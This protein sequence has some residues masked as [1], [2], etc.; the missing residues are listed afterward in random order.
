MSDR[1]R[2]VERLSRDETQS[3]HTQMTSL[4]QLLVALIGFA[5]SSIIAA[6]PPPTF[7]FKPSDHALGDVHPFFKDG[8]C[9]LYSLKPGKYDSV[10]AR[11]KDWLHWTETPITHT[12]VT[13]DD[14][15]SPY[16][17]LGVFRDEAAGVYR[18]FYGHARGRMVSSVS[19][20]LIDWS[21]APKE[22][23]VPPGDYYERRRD[24]FVFWI[25]ERKEY[26]CVMTTWMKGR[27]K[28]T[29]G[30]IS[31]ATSPDLQHWTDH[32][33]IIDPGNI[34]EPE[35]P[36]MFKLGAHWYLLASIYDRAVGKPDYWRS[37]SPTG[38]WKSAPEGQ[39]DGK[40]LCAAQIAIDGDTPLLFGWIPLTPAQPGKQ[41]WGGHLA[42]PREV[43]ALPDGSLGTRL[44]EK[45]RKA[46]STLDWQTRD[47][48]V[49]SPSPATVKGA[50][51]N[52]LVQFDVSI[53][54]P[55]ATVHVQLTPMG[56]V[57]LAVDA[58]RILDRHGACWSELPVRW[59]SEGT[60]RMHLWTDG[61]M[62][63]VFADD[64]WSLAARLPPTEGG[65][66]LVF[67]TQSDGGA[68]TR[69]RVT[70]APWQ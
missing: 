58:I 56:E 68:V 50:W 34:G 43:Y 7:H 54:K 62:V 31:L 30:A 11:S 23:S 12:P 10:L 59:R 55:N 36:Q 20:N 29:G 16:F 57:V 21:C 66:G 37:D 13:K 47:D 51:R 22:F 4:S 19:T 60:I 61:N 63:E 28:E 32:G 25:P 35:C 64:R 14:W 1:E 24:P 2:V 42:L 17:V 15:F 33:P 48:I 44:P 69:L 18:G 46:F 27:S 70:A 9:F 45:L 8:E 26:G 39:L 6:D 65:V 53:P 40:D 67:R 49:L 5:L 3:S 41:H 38:P 52:P